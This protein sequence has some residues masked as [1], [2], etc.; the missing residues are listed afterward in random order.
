M[1]DTHLTYG[2]GVVVYCMGDC[3]ICGR[4]FQFHPDLV[5][6]FRDEQG[7]RR[8]ICALCMAHGNALREQEGLPPHPIRKG[9]Y[10]PGPL[11]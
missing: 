1:D 3:W 4:L 5:P 2:G 10:E 7:V 6:S 11:V 8:P 9:A